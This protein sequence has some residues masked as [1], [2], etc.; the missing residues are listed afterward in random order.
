MTPFQPPQVNHRLLRL[1][2]RSRP[3]SRYAVAESQRGFIR[4]RSRRGAMRQ[5]HLAMALSRLPLH[6]RLN[7]DLE[8]Y[9]TNGEVAARWLMAIRNR[10]DFAGSP[11]GAGSESKSGANVLDL[12]AGN[13]I[14][15]IGA[16]LCG[17]ESV[18]LVECDPIVC[19][20]ARRALESVGLA[21]RSRVIEEMV[22]GHWDPSWRGLEGTDPDIVIMNPPWGRQKERADRPLIDTALSSPARI[23]HLMHSAEAT[24]IEPIVEDAGWKAER[25]LE[26]DLPLPATFRHH[27]RPRDS[28]RCAMW[29]ITRD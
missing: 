26:D 23:V 4:Q 8:Q 21:N 25:W 13:G 7:V 22:K 17:A 10:G 18:I 9:D 15:G 29:R 16:L 3:A 1:A 6:P 19:D 27:G 11:L 28:T 24:H 2:P 5:R 20:V 12:A 14:L